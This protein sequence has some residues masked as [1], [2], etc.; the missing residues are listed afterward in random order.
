M[1]AHDEIPSDDAVPAALPAGELHRAP[2]DVAMRLESDCESDFPHEVFN[3]PAPS[4]MPSQHPLKKSEND[5]PLQ[6]T[7][8]IE[9]SWERHVG[10]YDWSDETKEPQDPKEAKSPDES[11]WQSREAVERELHWLYGVV[12]I[13]FGDAIEA[14]ECVR[15]RSSMM[16][17]SGNMPLREFLQ[18]NRACHD[19]IRFREPLLTAVRQAEFLRHLIWKP[20]ENKWERTW[21]MPMA[22]PEVMWI[23]IVLRLILTTVNQRRRILRHGEPM[24]WDQGELTDLR[25]RLRWNTRTLP[26]LTRA[27]RFHFACLG[28]EVSAK[29]S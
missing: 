5:G 7:A 9:E 19:C 13:S 12:A 24:G 1:S 20:E 14:A 15:V 27:R 2:D 25:H 18:S 26:W 11:E 16:Q 6:T 28:E 23:R 29:I 10:P 22:G 21:D 17:A 3:R 4:P 8:Q